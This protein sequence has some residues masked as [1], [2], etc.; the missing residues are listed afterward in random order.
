MGK[1]YKSKCGIV[2]CL[3]A[4]NITVY[5]CLFIFLMFYVFIVHSKFQ[6]YI[7]I[8]LYRTKKNKVT[9]YKIYKSKERL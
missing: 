9:L 8:I 5:I 6:K 3:I 2:M 1:A 7:H 4:N